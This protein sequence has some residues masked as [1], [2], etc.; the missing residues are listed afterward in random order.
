MPPDNRADERAMA[1]PPWVVNRPGLDHAAR[2]E[3]A[4]RLSFYSPT[5]TR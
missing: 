1:D 4:D 5:P 3:I 2:L